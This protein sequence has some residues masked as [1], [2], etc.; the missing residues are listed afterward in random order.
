MKK[1][2]LSFVITLFAYALTEAQIVF[3]E[4]HYNA[5]TAQGPDSDCEFLELYNGYTN[6]IDLSGWSFSEGIS[7]VFP[8]GTMLASG[9]YL[10][11]TRGTG[12]CVD[13]DLSASVHIYTGALDNGGEAI[14]LNNDCGNVITTVTYT[15]ALDWA[16]QGDGDP[17]GGGQSLQ[18]T[19]TTNDANPANW[20][21][22]NLPNPQSGT[23]PNG[24]LSYVP[25]PCYTCDE[26]VSCLVITEIMIDPCSGAGGFWAT[27]GQG[28]FIEI[29]NHCGV[30]VNISGYQIKDEF[31]TSGYIVIPDGTMLDS[32]QYL[33]VGS[34][35][36]T[37]S[38]DKDGDHILDNGS[39]LIFGKNNNSS[40][41]DNTSPEGITLSDCSGN[42]IDAVSWTSA[43]CMT[44]N[45]GI[46]AVLLSFDS[47]NAN[48]DTANWYAS[49]A[50]AD[51][52][53]GGGTPGRPN[54]G[55]A[56]IKSIVEDITPVCNQQPA[57]GATFTISFD[58]AFSS[59][60][61]F[62]VYIDSVF[63]DTIGAYP[64]GA[65]DSVMAEIT[66]PCPVDF[67]TVKLELRPIGAVRNPCYAATEDI[68]VPECVEGTLPVELIT[69][70]AKNVGCD[71]LVNWQTVIEENFDRF[72]L[73][74]SSDGFL[75]ETINI[76]YGTG[77]SISQ[78]YQYFDRNAIPQNY[79]RLKMIDLDASF[80]FSAIILVTTDCNEDNKFILYPNP[81]NEEQNEVTIKF[82]TPS[83]TQ[84]VLL[85]IQD[86]HGRM[87]DSKNINSVSGWNS[88]V[89]NISDLP[90]GVFFFT[91][92]KN[93][94]KQITQ[95]LIR[96]KE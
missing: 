35:A 91:L 95:R 78:Q 93:G 94:S 32:G 10:I 77:G 25:D 1:L 43:G 19:N 66:L 87:L 5:S 54:I 21:D 45:D 16:G 26:D 58:Y 79:Y 52:I 74:R 55:G 29:Y 41:L 68:I 65:G 28:E 31:G 38:L 46:S 71:I 89:W 7:Y 59:V 37:D 92:S 67:D 50:V 42:V 15:D 27:E 85:T 72:E 2:V 23:L 69:F 49:L 88:L 84:Q 51:T 70:E 30:S 17:D 96:M 75:F 24:I 90:A 56:C 44:S 39:A 76:A 11:L 47:I 81:I 33:V 12:N 20:T 3:S 80:K 83:L 48:I 86:I 53:S 60:T 9:E 18:L 62:D 73:Q 14:T 34:Q 8:N 6:A 13:Y 22:A 57:C 40:E 61:T 63:L 4:I 64:I 82:F 36:I